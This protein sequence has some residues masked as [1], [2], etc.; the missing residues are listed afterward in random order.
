MNWILGSPMI[1]EGR[2]SYDMFDPNYGKTPR[3]GRG[4][5]APVPGNHP[6][7]TLDRS[8]LPHIGA[9]LE[10]AQREAG[11]VNQLLDRSPVRP[12]KE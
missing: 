11:K 4:K 8:G 1:R 6:F 2:M 12:D 5:F 3:G 10:E 9:T 7:V